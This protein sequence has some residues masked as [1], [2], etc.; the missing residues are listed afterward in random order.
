MAKGITKR[1]V[2]Y[3]QWY[4]DVVQRAE[5]ADYSPVRGCM[6]I[7]PNGYSV[8]ENI[9][10]S[11]DKMLKETGHVNAYFPFFIPKSFLEKEAAHVEGFAMECAVVTHSSLQRKGDGLEV[12]GELEEPLICRPTSETII[13]AMYK[14]WIQS[15]RDLPIL[16]NQWAN[17]IRWEMRT[18]LFL[19]TTE[20]LWQEGHTAHATKE[21]A[22]EEVL[23]IL[24]IY[25]RLAEE[26]LAMP[27]HTGRKT[28]AQRFPGAIETYC[29]E[30]MMQDG[31]ALQS[32]T[33]HDLGQNFAKAFDVKFQSENNTE[34]YVWAT[35][36]GVSTRLIG[37]LI[38]T[39]SDDDGFV[40]PPKLAANQVVIVPIY[41][42]EDDKVRVLEAGLKM[43][44]ALK[45]RGYGVIYDDRDQ[46]KPGYK[47]AE[48]ELKGI[49]LRIEIGPKDLDDGTCVL[50]TRH[51]RVKKTV[52]L[53][54]PAD[55][56]RV[57]LDRMQRELF[58]KAVD[59][60]ESKTRNVDNYEE[61]KQ[62]MEDDPGFVWAHWDGDPEIEAKIQ[63]ETK[64]TIRLIPFEYPDGPGRC[65]TS[66]KDSPG[67]VLFAKAY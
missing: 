23:R 11:L 34:E 60:R 54:N 45:E 50:A 9:K 33:S 40:V 56:V 7:R 16:Y 48:W 41:K 30:A 32:G 4:V 47:F 1:S 3:N 55:E 63:E 49:P 26:Y 18:R 15:F 42:A 61:F 59:Y 52:G 20:F 38:M 5:L 37:G 43:K 44:Q 46:F 22:G 36:W 13:W 57:S 67:R 10:E 62:I 25:R 14:K 39:H 28:A 17:I 31:R 29:I 58:Q 64:A 24:E 65:M 53:D 8:W 19:R 21:E 12:T 27:V 2:D 35:S 66:G 51:D 6:V